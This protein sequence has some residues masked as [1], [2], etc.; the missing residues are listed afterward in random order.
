MYRDVDFAGLPSADII[1]VDAHDIAPGRVII[2]DTQ[3]LFAGKFKKAGPDLILSGDDGRKLIVVDYYRG[4]KRPDLASPDGAILTSDVVDSLAGPAHP[5]QYAQVGVPAG[6]RLIGRVEKVS[7]TTSVQRATGAVEE[8]KLGDLLYQGDV[9]QTGQ[10]SSLGLSLID[11]TSFNMGANARMVLNEVVY[12]ANS[13]SNSALINIVLGSVTFVAGKIAKTGDMKL[14][15]PSATLGIRGTVANLVIDAN[16]VQ[17]IF[18]LTMALIPD[19]DGAASSIIEVFRKGSGELL[20]AYSSYNDKLVVTTTSGD[21]STLTLPLTPGEVAALAGQAQAVFQIQT[22]ALANPLSTQSIQ[23]PQGPQGPQA[24]HTNTPNPQLD[25]PDQQLINA[26]AG[27]QSGPKPITVV[28]DIISLPAS[29]AAES[30]PSELPQA[31]VVALGSSLTLFPTNPPDLIPPTPGGPGTPNSTP[32]PAFVPTYD[33]SALIANGWQPLSNNPASPLGNVYVLVAAYGTVTVNANATAIDP[34]ALAGWTNLGGG[35][36]TTLSQTLNAPVTVN[37]A[38]GSP[39]YA[40]DP[41]KAKPLAAG[42]HV[43]DPIQLPVVEQ[44]ATVQEQLTFTI[45]GVN[46]APVVTGAVTGSATVGGAAVTLDALTNATDPDAGTTLSVVLPGQLPAGVTYDAATHSFTFDPS[47]AAYQNSPPDQIIVNYAVSDGID[48][49][50]AQAIWTL[51]V[52]GNHQQVGTDVFL[53]GSFVEIGVAGSGSLGT[54]NSAPSTFHP[55]GFSEESLVF[56]ADRWDTGNA[57]RAGDVML[58]GTP[59]DSIVVGHDGKSFHNDER[60]GSNQI[61]ATTT[62][63]SSGTRLQA[64]TIGTTPDGLK[65]TQTIALDPNATYFTTTITLENVSG[66]PMSDVRF[67]RSFDPDQ[68]LVPFGLFATYNDVLSNPDGI[69]NIA[70]AQARGPSSGVSVNLIAFDADARA[71]NFGFFNWDP[72]IPAAFASPAD[73]NGALVDQ[74]IVLTLSFG[75]LAPGAQ[76]TKTFYTTLIQHDAEGN[77]IGTA[78]S[79]LL[80][81]GSG[82]VIDGKAGDDILVSVGADPAF[83]FRPGDGNDVVINFTPGV[84]VLALTGFSYGSFRDVQSLLHSA[85]GG[86]DTLVDF[87]DGNSF[88]LKGVAVADLHA[89][90]FSL[91]PPAAH[92]DAYTTNEDTPLVIAAAGV[93]AN[94]TDP[95]GNALS[96]SLVSNPAHGTLTFNSNGSL[97]YTPAANYFGADSF[98]YKASDGAADSNIATV[99]I[100]VTPVNDAPTTNDAAGSGDE[101]ATVAVALAGGDVDGAVASF[102]I[103]DGPANGTLYR[104]SGLTVQLQAGDSVPASGNA[105]HVYFKPA[106]NWNGSTSFHYAAVDELGLADATPAIASI[107]VTLVNDAS[108]ANDDT[109]R[110]GAGGHPDLLILTPTVGEGQNVQSALDALGLFA[111]IDI[112]TNTSTLTL[113]DLSDYEVVLTF[114]NFSYSNSVG[115]GDVLADFADLGGGV[116]I[117]TYALSSPWWIQGRIASTGYAPLTPTT[118]LA[119]PTGNVVATVP[120]DSIFDGVDLSALNGTFFVNSN[121][122]APGL[123]AGAQL[124]ATDGAG[125]NLIARNASGDVIALNFFPGFS[126]NTEFWTLFANSAINVTHVANEDSPSTIMTTRLL[127]NDT[128]ADNDP[129]IVTSV[130]AASALGALV[131]LNGTTITYDSHGL[132]E[133]LASGQSVVDSFAYTISDGHGRSASADVTLT[134]VGVNDAPVIEPLTQPDPGPIQAPAGTPGSTL[135]LANNFSFH[136][137]DLTDTHTIGSAFDTQTSNVGAPL[138]TLTVSLENDT[139]NGTGGLV[140]WEYDVAADLVNAIPAGT[141]RHEV[142]NVTVSDGHATAVK[143]VVITLDGPTAS[144]NAAPTTNDVSASGAEDTTVAVTLAGG[145]IDGTVASFTITEVP[146]NGTLY[147]DDALTQAIGI[148]DS[149]SASGNAATVYFRPAADWNGTTSFHYAAVDDLGLAD[150]TPAIASITVTLVNDAPSLASIS[151]PA[152]VPEAD[153]AAQQDIAPIHGTLSVTDAD[154]G[155]SLTA[156]AGAPVVLLDGLPFTLPAGDTFNGPGLYDSFI[157]D[158]ATGLVSFVAGDSLARHQANSFSADAIFSPDGSKIAFASPASNLVG[159]DAGGGWDIFVKDLTTGD[160]EL[161]TRN[162]AGVQQSGGQVLPTFGLAWSPDGRQVVFATTATNL[163]PNDNNAS[164]T[165]PSNPGNSGEDIFVKDITAP[166]GPIQLVNVTKDGTQ[167]NDISSNP[168]FSPDG[169]KVLFQSVATNLDGANDTNGKSDIFVKYLADADGH[170]AGDLIRVSTDSTGTQGT[171]GTNF[172]DSTLAVFSPDA[173]SV[174]FTSSAT[175]AGLGPA[176][177]SDIFVKYL[178]AANGHQAGDLVRV[179]TTTA[180]ADS[181]GSDLSP[182]FSPDGTKIVFYSNSTY[183]ITG[184][185]NANI[186]VFMKDLASGVVTR[187]SETA[188]HVVGNGASQYGSFS[189]DGEKILFFSTANNLVSGDTNAPAGDLAGADWFVKYL[190]DADGH[191]AG[192]IVRVSTDALGGQGNPVGTRGAQFESVAM[193]HWSPNSQFVTFD[194]SW[195][196][197]ILPATPL[198]AALSFSAGTA[199]GGNVSLDWTFDPAAANLDFVR[200]GQVLTLTYDVTVGDGT[201]SGNTQPLTIT[202][203]GTNDAPVLSSFGSGPTFFEATDAAAQDLGPDRGAIWVFDKDIGDR[204]TAVIVGSPVVKLDGVPFTLPSGAEALIAPG[205]LSA[206]APVTSDGGLKAITG[207][208]DP[209]TA[210]LDFLAA[211]QT[212]TITYSVVVNDE[213]ADS[214][215]QTLTVSILGTND[216]PVANAVA[217]AA[218]TEDTQYIISAADFIAA[219]VTDVDGPSLSITALSVASG[220]GSLADNGNGT[221]TYTPAANTN[222]PVTFNYTASDGTLTASSTASLTLAAVNDAPVVT[223]AVQGNATEDGPVVTLDALANASD[224]DS[225]NLFVTGVP[226][227]LPAG[228]SLGAAHSLGISDIIGISIPVGSAD[229]S[230]HPLDD[231]TWSVATPSFPL[232]DNQGIGYLINP[233]FDSNAQPTDFSLH[234]HQNIAPNVPDPTRAVITFQFASPTIVDRINVIEHTNGVTKLHGYV[235][236]S[237]NA[238]VDIGSVFG[239]LG[240]LTG[241]SQMFN[242]E[243]N[244]FNFNNTVAGTYF[245]VVIDKTSNAGGYALFRM[246]LEGTG[247]SREFALDPSDPAYQYLAAGEQTTVT[248]NYAV[249]DGVTTTPASVSWTITGV[250]D[251]PVATPVALAA[252]AEDVAYTIHAADLLAHVTDVDSA[253]LSITALSIASGGGALLDNGGGTWTYTPSANTNGP[254]SFDYTASDGSLTASS[255]ASLTLAAVNDAPVITLPP[256]GLFSLDIT[257]VSSGPNGEVGNGKSF[258]AVFS[259]DGTKVAFVSFADNFVSGDTNGGADVF[260]KDLL[261]GGITRVSTASDGSQAGGIIDPVFPWNEAYTPAFS[262]DGTKLAFASF[263]NNLVLGDTNGKIDIFIKDL[264]TGAV[265]RESIGAQGAQANGSS[266]APAFSPDGTKLLFTSAA[267]NLAPGDTNNHEDIFIKDVGTGAITRIAINTQVNEVLPG[268]GA[269]FS[270]DGTKAAYFLYDTSQS[271]MKEFVVT[272]LTTGAEF[273]TALPANPGSWKLS[274]SPDSSKVAFA[275]DSDS[276]VPG[277]TNGTFNA[278][279][280]NLSTGQVTSVATSASG[281]PANSGSYDGEFLGNSNEISF[282]STATN[283]LPGVDDGAV[284]FY[285]KNLV[286]GEVRLPTISDFNLLPGNPGVLNDTSRPELPADTNN[287]N[288]I[289]LATQLNFIE[290]G[291]PKTI[292]TGIANDLSVIVTSLPLSDVDNATLASATVQITG[293]LHASE[294]VLAFINN[295][296]TKFGNIAAAYNAASGLLSLASPGATA[297]LAQWQDA[298]AAVTYSNTSD[299]PSAQTRTIS[300]QVDDGQSINHASNVVTVTVNVTPVNDAPTGSAVTKTIAEDQVASFTAADFG[301]TDAD[302][303]DTLHGVKIT[304]IPDAADGQLL[305]NNTAIAAGTIVSAA[306][307]ANLTFAPANRSTSYAATFTVQVEDQSLAL[308]PAPKTVTIEVTANDTNPVLTGDLTIAVLRGGAVQLTTADFAAL[309]PDNAASELIYSV[310][311]PANGHVVV[312]SDP[313]NLPTDQGA[314]NQP[315]TQADL[316]AGHVFFVH[317]GADA[318]LASLFTVSVS[319]GVAGSTAARATVI[320][321]ATTASFS[322]TT[323][324]GWDFQA[325]SQISKIGAGTL[326]A[327]VTDHQ[328]IIDYQDQNNSANDRSF[329]FAG[330]FIHNG[331]SLTG[332]VIT[333]IREYADTALA[334]ELATLAFGITG[335]LAGPNQNLPGVDAV[336]FLSAAQAEASGDHAPIAALAADWSMRFTGNS[337]PDAFSS[338]DQADYFVGG[339]GNDLFDG[340]SGLDRANYTAAAAGITVNLAIGEVK[341]TAPGD[342]AGIG[343]DTLRSIEFVGGTNDADIFDATGFSASSVN[344]GS[345][346]TFN[347]NGTFNQFEGRGG[348]DIITGNDDTRISYAHALD[349]VIVNLSTGVATGIAAGDAAGV[350]TDSFTH[351]NRVTGSFYDDTLIGSDRTDVTEFFDGRGGNDNI[352]GSGGGDIAVYNNEPGPAGIAVDMAAGVVAGG[353]NTGTDTLRRIEGIIGTEF[354]DNYDATG[355]GQAGALNVGDQGTNNQ[356]EGRGGNDSVTGNGN[357]RVAFNQAT[358][359]VVVVLGLGGTGSASGDDSVGVDTYLGGVSRVLGSEFSD[360]IFGNEQDNNLDGRGGNDLLWGGA[361]NDVLVG[362]TGLDR[363]GYEDATGPVSINLAAGTVT[364]DAS[365]GSDTLRSIEI[366]RGS[367]FDDTY[368]AVGFSGA[369]ANAGSAGAFNIFEGVGGNDTITGNGST[370]VDYHS[371]TR[372]VTVDLSTGQAHST[373]PLAVDDPVGHD[374]FTGVSGLSGS[375]FL[376]HLTGSNTTATVESYLGRG[377][378]DI[379]TGGGGLDLALYTPNIAGAVTGGINVALAA[380]NVTGD[381]SVGTD[382]LSSVEMVQGTP[383][384]DVYDATG[385]GG[386][387]V[388]A[389]SNGSFNQFEGLGGDDT[390]T[391]NGNTR[392]SF[393]NATAGVTVDLGAG[394]ATGDASVGADTITGG[395]NAVIGSSFADRFIGNSA[396]NTFTG[397]GESDVFVFS[398]GSGHDTIA[399]FTLGSDLIDLSSFHFTEAELDSLI[400][401]SSGNTLTIDVVGDSIVFATNIADVHA[402]TQA[403]FIR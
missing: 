159:G 187:I 246:F 216:A 73:S 255:T 275:I 401:T 263:A 103:T 139:A 294:D 31:P 247:A 66:T 326:R 17:Q 197:L 115:T 225:A 170:S 67:M 378:D 333:E 381:L 180:G 352:D 136:D 233:I 58:P 337:G 213:T 98:T 355:F 338:L 6:A 293:N 383:F 377:G 176:S 63:T 382:T 329:V 163:V 122:A 143:Q 81:G 149:V 372:E 65:L 299:N 252:G 244:V 9:V 334:N 110:G 116:V 179:S 120:S 313:D 193:P 188:S 128:D 57:P 46:D 85:N 366:V 234:D 131:T 41:N 130:S 399:D 239:S 273:R 253:N 53:Q 117:A 309:D 76:L 92:D 36:F 10:G 177:G 184:D 207:T 308:D 161:V 342:A 160:I 186:D 55:Q 132:F 125:H 173:T 287:V 262:P 393:A 118:T 22:Q 95:D 311:A 327:G 106:D 5:A 301:F 204:L 51:S 391:G 153:A 232:N 142:F 62:D 210:N 365:V 34:A 248:V 279:V 223:G 374:T 111:T 330:N 307:V 11:G 20:T 211:G 267:S 356:F 324:N 15:T 24:P 148:G 384:A 370:V 280:M 27:D 396:N 322:V 289:Y 388:N 18:R 121:F 220:G 155:D 209:G 323:P 331:D 101:D 56:D 79:D 282:H 52:G 196:N 191:V 30:K 306:D 38:P 12:D 167:A 373:V 227:L 133:Y 400:S 392:I 114:S 124:L 264:V 40:L 298:L 390:I 395:V 141:E 385:F 368:N 156:T 397:G 198:A 146:A 214:A 260:I 261:T 97:V 4:A 165:F 305:L 256:S 281:E 174:A 14:E 249:S 157:K 354:A 112:S 86:Q 88:M 205:A 195:D 151:P 291:P 314:W 166:N 369:S 158:L 292:T 359:G 109:L 296:G 134:V 7:G 339:G 152:S 371:S 346:L 127:A 348:D 119:T 360:S 353:A 297:T 201:V 150:A 69:Q 172:G 226:A 303:G 96:A 32:P 100:T 394:T 321:A 80:V 78:G 271:V 13:T 362:G 375:E 192:D 347:L 243:L 270:P 138:G 389:G 168:Q 284:H 190:E 16:L 343:V 208:Y 71:S 403:N 200:E 74:A 75:D 217:L 221:W 242:G 129:L 318:D 231:N 328:F 276:V 364:G 37:V 145:D 240:D 175:F 230:S 278:L 194:G 344:A 266:F 290:N 325:E 398:S 3:L 215:P 257:L 23:N 268:T 137:I 105:A 361:G 39:T 26:P 212:L 265:T 171:G 42:Q 251:A 29:G 283:L 380:G 61:P 363:T 349:A 295:D 164:P 8:L 28:Q 154:A 202:I 64:T 241:D 35:N 45:I 102:R 317:S 386:A 219:G 245:Q 181:G 169:K 238:L 33:V 319:D 135:Q 93:L 304:T 144:I 387:S 113:G 82:S 376:D 302:A 49:V 250:N 367:N 315:F 340:R 178:V 104:D 351:V 48:T 236:N 185:T 259:P 50:S 335:S 336:A 2:P 277:V 94:D 183:G 199:N 320:A 90:D 59:E 1:R 312:S 70:V 162:A 19:Q 316:A 83:V 358:S 350:G 89:S 379:I 218:G 269:H 189:P 91:A 84:D 68:D 44:G 47:H 310:I 402:L 60:V 345:T 254:V 229:A 332:G 300:I 182:V 224:I 87:G 77:P 21:V 43:P 99:T 228:V 341:G 274:F 123:D 25:Q 203:T 72:Y 126:E 222:G 288:D 206:D 286:T 272:N 54:A 237:L 108:V 140:H 235:G 258:D 357:T 285:A 147:R 107:T